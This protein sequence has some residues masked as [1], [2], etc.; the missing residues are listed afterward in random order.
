ML[1]SWLL[2]SALAGTLVID[3]KVP[4]E[5]RGPD[6]VL[7]QLY[8]P[9]VLSVDL[10]GGTYEFIVFRN[11]NPETIRLEVPAEG[12]ARMV[13]GEAGITAPPAPKKTEDLPAE[14]TVEFRT[15]GTVAVMVQLPDERLR[16]SP[17][18]AQTVTLPTGTHAMKVR[19][20]DGTVIW[21][22]G[23]LTLGGKDTVVQ[24]SEGRGPEV[25]GENALWSTIRQ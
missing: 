13:V 10:D 19:S 23:E 14:T 7:A 16:V 1:I 8:V 4:T 25:S 5:I 9:S 6:A 15:V 22:R 20:S 2:G 11:G 17:G 21:A 24:L 3:A 18:H 12:T